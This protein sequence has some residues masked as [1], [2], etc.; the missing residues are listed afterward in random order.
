M[1]GDLL[2][3][4]YRQ[5]YQSLILHEEGGAVSQVEEVRTVDNRVEQIGLLG[6]EEWPGFTVHSRWQVDGAVYH[7][8]HSHARTQEYEARY[9]VAR[10]PTGWRIRDHEILA[11][12]VIA[13]S[14]TD[15][16]AAGGGR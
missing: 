6:E 12:E 15:P 7:W 1:H 14:S 4:L 2:D 3:R 16:R 9:T 13:T 10:T 5:V 11:Q 8:G